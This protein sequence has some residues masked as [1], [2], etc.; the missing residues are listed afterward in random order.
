[1][2]GTLNPATP[3]FT[4]HERARTRRD[5]GVQ[6]VDTY[7]GPTAGLDTFLATYVGASAPIAHPSHSGSVLDE[8]KERYDPSRT[9]VYVDLTYVPASSGYAYT[10]L[11]PVGS[12]VIEAEPVTEDLSEKQW[13]ALGNSG[14]TFPEGQDSIAKPAVQVSVIETVRNYNWSEAELSRLSIGKA[15]PSGYSQITGTLTDNAWSAAGCRV[16]EGD[17][18]AEITRIWMFRP[19][20]APTPP[21]E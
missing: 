3:S 4:L 15:K 18:V 2:S 10:P 19:W 7:V 20:R 12:I 21:A 6:I 5:G 17:G 16:R 13:I 14:S 1:M 11:R 9:I 8:I